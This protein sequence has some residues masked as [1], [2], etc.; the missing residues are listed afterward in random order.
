M[1]AI[2]KFTLPEEELEFHEATNGTGYRMAYREILEEIR[3]Y[4]K[5]G[6]TFDSPDAVLNSL[7][8]EML[9]RLNTRGL[10]VYSP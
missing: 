1:R 9:E 8:D 6:H 2:L 4:K 5:H 10:D 7:Y 3:R